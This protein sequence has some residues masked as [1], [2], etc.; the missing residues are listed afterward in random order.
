M[1]DYI[2]GG[3]SGSAGLLKLEGFQ[4]VWEALGVGQELMYKIMSLG[5]GGVHMLESQI[6][7]CFG[8]PTVVN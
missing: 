4:V 7:M 3:W 6:G 8:G 1:V 5:A 2:Y